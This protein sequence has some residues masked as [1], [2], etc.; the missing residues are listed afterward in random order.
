[1]RTTERKYM[2]ATKLSRIALLSKDDPSKEF[3]Q[4]MHHFN[5][6]S[7]MVCANELS[8]NKAI[9]AD[10]VTKDQYMAQAGKNIKGLVER[11]KRMGYRPGNVL[12]VQIPKDDKP[13]AFRKLGI[14]NFED[15]IVQKMMQKVLESVYEPLFLECSFG[16]RPGRGCQDALKGLRNHLYS[17]PTAVVLDVDLAKYFDSISHQELEIILRKKIKDEKLMRYIIRMFKAGVLA[18]GELRVSEEGVYQGSCCS[19]ILA[20][21]FAHYVIDEWFETVVKP[22]CS[23][24]TEMFRYA[25]DIIMCCENQRDAER[26]KKALGN[27]LGKFKLK[28][29]EEK[30]KVISMSRRRANQGEKQGTFDFLG[31]TIYL[32]KSRGGYMIPKLKTSSKRMRSKL[33]KFKEWIKSVRTWDEAC[34]WK[35]FKQKLDGHIQYFGVSFN[36]KGIQLF[37]HKTLKLMLK[38]LNRRSQRRSYTMEAF[39]K[40]VKEVYPQPLIKIYWK[41]F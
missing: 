21:I 4:L 34:I 18:A 39:G 35:R 20:N 22:H 26:V 19:P 27:R 40:V 10:G 16:F 24:V 32:G 3:H 7:L 13:G 29:N 15:K 36:I 12:E 5:E 2:T 1:M 25:D 11:M 37:Y 8:G 30:T 9:G 38:W 33:K 31:F 17:K 6:E 23:G 41:L 14:S 28:M